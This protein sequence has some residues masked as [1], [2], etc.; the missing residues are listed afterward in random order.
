MTP[1]P[2]P[3][4]EPDA[5]GRIGPTGPG[6]LAVLGV[7]G[8]FGGWAARSIAIRSGSPV[9][10]I[11]WLAVVVVWFVVAV[12]AG[13]AYLTWRT[14]REHRLLT[15]QQGVARL[16]LG[17]TIDRM[18][19]FVLGGAVGYAISNLGVDGDN[20]QRM[21]LRAGV[22]AVGAA[23]GVAA[24]LLLEHACRVP[25]TDPGDLP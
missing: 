9:P 5:P 22:A 4:R 14:V 21:V 12:T 24:G 7:L 19:A 20:A 3:E 10:T 16:V 13:T 8:L 18:A 11:S 15:P 25:P 6:P 17:K 1:R 2:E 23:A